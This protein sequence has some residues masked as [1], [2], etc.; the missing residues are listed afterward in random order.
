MALLSLQTL[1]ITSP[2]C[3]ESTWP[4][5]GLVKQRGSMLSGSQKMRQSVPVLLARV[6]QE[7]PNFASEEVTA[8][9]SFLR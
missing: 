9:Q 1:N 2:G 7:A 3:N 6:N 4:G 8:L 5:N